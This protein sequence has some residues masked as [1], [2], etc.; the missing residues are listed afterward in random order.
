M[1][2][3]SA[4]TQSCVRTDPPDIGGSKAQAAM[5]LRDQC[6]GWEGLCAQD[7]TRSTLDLLVE[8][9]QWYFDR[10]L[11]SS[12]SFK[13]VAVRFEVKWENDAKLARDLQRLVQP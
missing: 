2:Q 9:H 7:C 13:A 1:C 5:S 10:F 12:E 11:P 8:S 3:R 4:R 6:C